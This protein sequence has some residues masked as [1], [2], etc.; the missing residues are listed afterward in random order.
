MNEDDERVKRE[1]KKSDLL[2]G[3][4]SV[5]GSLVCVF[6]LNVTV[7]HLAPITFKADWA[8]CWNLE[9]FFEHLAIAGA[10]GRPV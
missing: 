9:R 6:D 7:F 10:V 4:D 3:R 5:S 1:A 2:R 8:I